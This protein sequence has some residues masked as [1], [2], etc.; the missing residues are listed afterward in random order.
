MTELYTLSAV[1][2]REIE[3]SFAAIVRTYPLY[4][5]EQCGW[6]QPSI[7]LDP[8]VRNFWK[9]CRE[10]ITNA[11]DDDQAL[12]ACQQTAIETDIEFDLLP[13]IRALPPSAMPQAYAAEISRRAY[14]TVLSVRHQELGRALSV[15]DH[16]KA[17]EIVQAMNAEIPMMGARL[18][19]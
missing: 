8:R 18:P 6:L 12:S 4:T 11:M 19:D 1:T 15:G 2:Q 10:R 7:L 17:R 3:Q 13:Q 5:L 9:L 16:E 14:M